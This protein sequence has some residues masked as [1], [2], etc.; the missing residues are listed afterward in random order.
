VYTQPDN[1]GADARF[2][3][4]FAHDV[5]VH[6]TWIERPVETASAV[7]FD[8]PKQRPVEICAMPG[9]GQIGLDRTLRGG[10]DGH[11][12]DL[13][14]LAFNPEMHDALA[15]MQVLYPETAELFTA[16]P[17]IEQ[18]GQQ[19][20]C[21]M[22]PLGHKAPRPQNHRWLPRPSRG[23]SGEPFLLLPSEYAVGHTF[24]EVG[25]ADDGIY[26]SEP[27]PLSY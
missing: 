11:K 12:A 24:V 2:S 17:M 27:Q 3:T 4:V 18:G 22:A 26:A 23:R 20:W 15:A 21:G 8:R 1:F 9:H 10:I 14:A 6:R 19:R 25:R 16:D 7:V 5:P 13:G